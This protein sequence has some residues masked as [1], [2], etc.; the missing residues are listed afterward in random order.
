VFCDQ[1]FTHAD[2]LE[3]RLICEALVPQGLEHLEFTADKL[4]IATT[5]S[6]VLKNFANMET[7]L[8]ARIFVRR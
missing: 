2:V 4:Q 6:V 5:L 1:Y 8:A 7:I 3:P